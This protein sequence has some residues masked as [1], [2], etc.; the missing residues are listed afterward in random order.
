MAISDAQRQKMADYVRGYLSRTAQN[1]GHH[2]ALFRATARWTHTLNVRKNV[3]LILDGE[4]APPDMRDV[5]EVAA[6][7]HDIDHYTV[8]LEYH[9]TRGA[10]TT[11]RFLTKEEYAPDFVRRVA[12]T[13]REHHRDLDDAIPVEEQARQLMDTLTLEA[14]ILLDA[15]TLDKIG[16]SNI[17]QA[18]LLMGNTKRQVADA[19]KELTSGWPLQRAELWKCLLT[20]LTGQRLGEERFVFYEHFLR[21]VGEEIVMDDPFPAAARAPEAAQV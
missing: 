7:F 18:V 4:N 19:A 2:N 6:F 16:A 14:R 15:D 10:E 12:D 20:T 9:A 21:Q 1:F 11:T 8:Q 17:M 3:L 13:I 5:C